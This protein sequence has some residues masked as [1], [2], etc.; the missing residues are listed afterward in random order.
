[1]S[2]NDYFK[3][4]T[5]YRAIAAYMVFCVHFNPGIRGTDMHAFFAGFGIGVPLFFAL[6]GF[7]IYT[8]YNTAE[9]NS[10]FYKKYMTNRFARIYPVY[11]LVTTV[12]LLF[13]YKL[14]AFTPY[15]L[16]VYFLNITFLRGFFDKYI[17]TLV[18][19][20]WSL[21]VEEVFYVLAPI[22]FLLGAN[23][24]KR[25]FGVFIVLFA[26]GW[27]L[28]FI[29][30]DM[31]HGFF[32][33]D[34]KFMI[35]NTFFGHSFAFIM[36]IMVGVLNDRIKEL[37]FKYV[38]V[39]GFSGLFLS[40]FLLSKFNNVTGHGVENVF[41]WKGIMIYNFMAVPFIGA[42]MWGL[43][44]ERTWL[45]SLLST[46]VF[47]VLGKSSYSF[48]L[49][50]FGIVHAIIMRFITENVFLLFLLLVLSALV[51]WRFVEEP[52]NERIRSGA[53]KYWRI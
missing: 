16:K 50:H 51:L 8:R 14:A 38:T 24:I 43:V 7:L 44:R 27:I 26:I 46:E 6:S 29:S 28:S 11:F 40:L 23:S 17:G 3:A 53:K 13:N 42:I 25:Y 30:V 19:Q 47:Q 35:L 52:M 48:Y 34:H 32:W 41:T 2:K 1:L 9:V 33:A 12:T 15:W 5:G 22:L 39:I 20:G 18:G 31:L 36:G 4:L 45:S 21:T 37:N 49:I 10:S